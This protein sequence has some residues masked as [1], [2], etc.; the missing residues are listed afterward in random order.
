M[1]TQTVLSA[2]A[3]ALSHPSA[4][5]SALCR[6]SRGTG[7]GSRLAE[8]LIANLELEIP[9][10]PRK[11]T[12]RVNSN[13]KYSAIFPT[14]ERESIPSVRAFKVTSVPFALPHPRKPLLPRVADRESRATKFRI[15]NTRLRF[16]L[17]P[18]K[19]S[20]LEIS[21]RERMAISCRACSLL[22]L[23]ASSFQPPEPN[24]DIA[25]R[26][27]NKPH[28]FSHFQF[29]NRDKRGCLRS[30]CICGNRFFE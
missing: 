24:R 26:N 9:A 5:D 16:G 17:S 12:S 4:P 27:R 30:E 29:S 15:A 7:S 23:R 8:F 25:I 10:S 28:P 18:T 13:R 21:N 22:Q 19:I 11:Q 1:M 20:I 2:A 3:P 14:Q 6:F